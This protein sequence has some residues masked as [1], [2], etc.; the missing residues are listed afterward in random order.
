MDNATLGGQ[1]LQDKILAVFFVPFLLVI[2]FSPAPFY[3][4][5]TEAETT[6]KT[7]L[8]K[9]LT[10]VILILCLFFAGSILLLMVSLPF[11]LA[12]DPD[13]ILRNI[14]ATAV[15]YGVLTYGGH[16]YLAERQRR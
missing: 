12:W 4:R 13:T 3:A 8:K 1:E 9:I 6:R 11:L 10:K 16:H 15:S 7:M 14:F 5:T 2:F